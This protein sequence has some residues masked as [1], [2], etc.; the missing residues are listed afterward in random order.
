MF[1]AAW[2]A[3]HARRRPFW[4]W[5]TRPFRSLDDFHRRVDWLSPGE[6]VAPTRHDSV[7]WQRC[8]R[9]VSPWYVRVLRW[10]VPDARV[11]VSEI[12]PARPRDTSEPTS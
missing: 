10:I 5:L 12:M 1:D 4:E 9:D 11:S 2:A 3:N 8:E 7:D 6:A